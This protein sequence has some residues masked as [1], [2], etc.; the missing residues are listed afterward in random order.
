ML[1]TDVHLVVLG[2]GQLEGWVRSRSAEPGLNGRLHL[3]PAV[4]PA[5]LLDWVASA[6]VAAMPIQPTTLN[7]RLTTP[8][9]LLEAMAAGIPVVASNLPGMAGIVEET[10][11]GVLCDPAD[12]ASVAAAIAAV[13]AATPAEREARRERTLAAARGAYSWEAQL[14]I[15][16]AE[17]GRL[18]GRPW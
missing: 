6:D 10:G 8:N 5:D 11:C 1:P 3:L 17:Y 14:D 4:P 7:H 12:P 13:L 2:Y 9:K 15:L 18:T 16:L